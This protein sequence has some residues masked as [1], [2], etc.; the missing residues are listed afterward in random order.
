MTF[1]RYS[2]NNNNINISTVSEE[3][4]TPVIYIYTVT[5]NINGFSRMYKIRCLIEFWIN[6]EIDGN[7][8]HFFPKQFAISN[9][10]VT[11]MEFHAHQFYRLVYNGSN[12]PNTSVHPVI[13]LY[14]EFL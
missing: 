2:N 10:I 4:L 12:I 3:T 9:N 7:T 13:P 14:S 5:R 11:R 1:T 8:M 6:T